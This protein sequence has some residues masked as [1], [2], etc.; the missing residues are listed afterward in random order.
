MVKGIQRAI[1][2]S[3]VTPQ[4]AQA[5]KPAKEPEPAKESTSPPVKHQLRLSPR[6][7]KINHKDTKN[8]KNNKR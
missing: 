1:P 6:R 7:K 3:K 5:A 4:Q 8:T 2:G